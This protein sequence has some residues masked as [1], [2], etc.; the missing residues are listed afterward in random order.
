[1]LMPPPKLTV[2]QWADKERRLDAQ[3]SS[4]PGRWH[5]SRAEYQ[6]GMMDALNEPNVSEVIIMCAAQLGKSETLNNIIGYYI[7]SDPCPMLMLQPT[8][9]MA[10]AYSKDRIAAG[11]IRSTPCLQGKVKDPRSRD[12]G[13][14]TLHKVFPGGAL[15]LVGAN[16][17]SGLA[18]RPIRVILCDEVDRYPSSAGTEGDPIQLARKRTATFWNR[19]IVLVST[20]TNKGASRI[21]ESYEKSDKRKFWVPCKHCEESQ[22]LRWG[23]VK[24]TD[25]EPDSAMYECDSCHVLWSENDRRWS[26]KRGEWRAEE[27]LRGIAGF[28][29]NALYSPWTPLADGVREFLA[30]RKAPEQ[31]RVWIN[32][33]LAETWEDQGEVIDDM[34]LAERRED[35]GDL[36]PEEVML[37]TCGVDVQQDRL[38]MQVTGWASDDETYVVD[39]KTI[40]GDPSVPS[41]WEALSS[42]LFSVFETHDGRQLGLR[43][44]CIDS[45]GSHTQTVYKYCKANGGRRVFAIKG[46]GGDRPMVTKPSSNN[47]V[48]CPLFPVGVDNAKDLLMA[49]L[50]VTEPGAGYVHFSDTLNEEYF[51][52]LT[53]EK[54]VLKYTR[55]FAKRTYVKIRPRNESLDCFVYSMAAYAILNVDVNAMANRVQYERNQEQKELKST[56]E[57]K[58]GSFV[59]K[60]GKG[61]VNSWR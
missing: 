25:D 61:F 27:K 4:E 48:K 57:R 53:A 47:S 60:T 58:K 42:H 5:T 55:G 1:M 18:S 14:T 11:L 26:I 36:V 31:L 45:G 46:V 54:V 9:D 50:K 15:T 33:Y 24:W 10:Q 12:S 59:P 3:S 44:I 29:I 40:Y 7:D 2:S 37:L 35:F 34:A 38:E 20:P 23:N 43:S 6:R 28:W 22:L 8:V 17:P 30:V 19:K 41:T 13:N 56:P 32:T 16:S 39:Y 52:M 51:K 49:R 21:E